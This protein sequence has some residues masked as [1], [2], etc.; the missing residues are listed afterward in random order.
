MERIELRSFH[1]DLIL[2]YKILFDLIV[3][4]ASN[5]YNSQTLPISQ[6][7]F[8]HCRGNVWQLFFAER[9]FK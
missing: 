1:S 9:V 3:I 7:F 8:K 6:I 2:T 4:T 5:L